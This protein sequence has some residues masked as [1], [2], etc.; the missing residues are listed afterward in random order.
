MAPKDKQSR[1]SRSWDGERMKAEGEGEPAALGAERGQG[2]PSGSLA[3]RR[4][5]SPVN[6][7]PAH[8]AHI[9]LYFNKAPV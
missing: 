7:V 1:L 3:R 2:H 4:G 6:S 5:D 8:V 9:S